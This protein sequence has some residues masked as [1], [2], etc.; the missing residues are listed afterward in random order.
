MLVGLGLINYIRADGTNEFD[1]IPVDIV[2]NHIIVATA[3][4]INHPKAIAVYNC[5]T[6]RTNPITMEGYKD[7]MVHHFKYVKL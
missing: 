6:S 2:T 7:A 5:G 1:M 4:G 3:N